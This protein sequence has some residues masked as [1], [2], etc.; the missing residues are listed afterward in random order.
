MVNLNHSTRIVNSD[1]LLVDACAGIVLRPLAT[2]R[3]E[4]V[5]DVDKL[6]ALADRETLISVRAAASNCGYKP[7]TLYNWIES[8]KLRNEHGLRPWGKRWRIDWAVFKPG[9]V[10]G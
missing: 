5:C 8:G 7:K 10:G 9:F 3:F 2:A 6:G 1:C 4:Y